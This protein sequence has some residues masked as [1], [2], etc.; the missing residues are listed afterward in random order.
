MGSFQDT[1]ETLKPPFICAFEIWRTVPLISILFIETE[2]LL[3]SISFFFNFS[4]VSNFIILL[5]FYISFLKSFKIFLI[6]NFLFKSDFGS[7]FMIF[8]IN[9]YIYFIRLNRLFEVNLW[10]KSFFSENKIF[11]IAVSW[12]HS[13]I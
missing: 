5:H 12:K 9:F 2:F 3:W 6:C 1:F 4:I 10:F 11:K 8:F 7:K 13:H